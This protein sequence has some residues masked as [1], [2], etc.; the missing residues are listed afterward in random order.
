MH[1]LLSLCAAGLLLGALA[2]SPTLAANDRETCKYVTKDTEAAI[3][4]C[5]RLISAGGLRGP[6]LANAYWVRGE[7]HRYKR[8]YQQAVEDYSEA[9]RINPKDLQS[10]LDRGTAYARLEDHDRAIADFSMVIRVDKAADQTRVYRALQYRADSYKEKKDYDRA[11]AD[12]SED[13]RLRPSTHES[14]FYRAMIYHYDKGEHARAIA[15][16]NEAIRLAAGINET[17]LELRGDSYESLGQTD[18]ALADFRAAL[19][20]DPSRQSARERIERLEAKAA[21]PATAAAVSA[22]AAPAAVAASSDRDACHGTPPEALD[23]CSR[24]IA[25]GTLKGA[26]LAEVYKSRGAMYLLYNIDAARA[27]AD[28]NE[29][30]RLDPGQYE[31]Y[32][33]R[34]FSYGWRGE[35]DRAIAE[36]SEAIR[37]A[38][39]ED[40]AW[41]PRA[42]VYLYHKQDYDRA[43][44][45]ADAGIA[46]SRRP[47]LLYAVRGRAHD[48]K[49][50]SDRAA[51][52]RQRAIELDKKVVEQFDRFEQQLAATG[53]AYWAFLNVFAGTPLPSPT[54][55]AA[56]TDPKVLAAQQRKP[57]ED[58]QRRAEDTRNKPADRP[59]V[60]A[61]PPTAPAT[62]PITTPSAGAGRRVALVIGNA[63]YRSVAA[64]PNPRADAAAIAGALRQ[65]GFQV[66]RLEQDLPRDKL[67]DAL[68][69]FAREADSADWALVYY[70]GHGIEA[71]GTNY[72]VPVD[73]KLEV[74]R[75]IEYETVP[76]NQVLN[77]VEGARKLK[78]VLLDACR[79]NPFARQ[80]RRT[81]A[82]RSIGRGLAR[83]EPE[84]GT[85]VAYAARDGQIA[86]DGSGANSPFVA[87]LVKHLPT[88]GVEISKLFRLV[89]DDV[90]AATGRKQEPY[91][92]GALSG[93]DFFFV[94]GK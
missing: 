18:K 26:A 1:R 24:L 10:Y 59:V 14:R 77:T 61:A 75:D 50:A 47:A 89:H 72:L 37:L 8:E 13:I 25:S 91:V 51:A 62:A 34:A 32:L 52:D 35:H 55:A 81:T 87:A 54:P 53:N 43:L 88:P 83:V 57:Q 45:D 2:G 6:A 16:L 27:L 19:A 58:L 40:D 44:A 94:A 29:V 82:T 9:I 20:S 74:D 11:I 76:L 7:A 22:P 3:A 80:M 23:A 15:D 93:E 64:L 78:I 56:A 49:G 73:A 5:S 90:L 12:Y 46:V 63:A 21:A 36:L 92:Y 17:Y 30:I 38:P 65:V 60:A 4:A 41:L 48:K 68:R 42:L 79:D 69:T 39:K 71:N 70:A 85:L 67:I 86:L 66:V 31:T 33:L 84:G 28:I